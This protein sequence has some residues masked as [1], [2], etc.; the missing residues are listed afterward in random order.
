MQDLS[1]QFFKSRNQKVLNPHEPVG[2]VSTVFSNNNN[3]AQIFY[4]MVYDEMRV[5]DKMN[6]IV[7]ASQPIVDSITRKFVLLLQFIE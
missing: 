2:T 4:I 3:N 6:S 5:K 7:N 1:L